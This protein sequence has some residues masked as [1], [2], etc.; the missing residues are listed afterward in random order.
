MIN[1]RDIKQNII[2]IALSTLLIVQ[3]IGCSPLFRQSHIQPKNP[4]E[5]AMEYLESG[6]Y[7]AALN[8]FNKIDQTDEHYEESLEYQKLAQEG[9]S[10]ILLKRSESYIKSNNF[11]KAI[12]TAK[13]AINVYPDIAEKANDLIADAN[14]INSESLLKSS[15]K[16][17]EDG[18]FEVAYD[19]ADKAKGLNPN[20]ND[21]ANTLQC[22]I[23]RRHSQ[24]LLEQSK[25]YILNESYESAIKAANDAISVLPD[26]SEEA[27]NLIDRAKLEYLQSLLHQS[28]NNIEN[29]KFSQA[30]TAA[31]KAI[32]IDPSVKDEANKLIEIAE[33][34]QEEIILE[35]KISQMR[36]FEGNG[37]V[38][39]SAEKVISQS[40]FNY[41]YSMQKLEDPKNTCFLLVK[42]A[43]KNISDSTVHVNPNYITLVV[44]KFVYNPDVKTYSMDNYLEGINLRPDT[45]TAGWV[46]F[47]VPKAESYTLVYEGSFDKVIEKE[48]YVTKTK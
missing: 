43:V 4:F 27:N 45:I 2:L 26:V 35:E 29:N 11:S 34:K 1:R 47:I 16:Y 33:T 14:R 36:L 8:A 31:K 40:S 9:Y 39:V 42:L 20:I 21:E 17:L 41:G 6:Q 30:I 22:E 46:V 10:Q 25:N 44:D 38:G 19:L 24:A 13:E 23:Q 7:E 12:D 15:R 28:R 5:Q 32:D 18:L 37:K 3:I 48:I